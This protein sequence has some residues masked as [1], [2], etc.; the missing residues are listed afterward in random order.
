MNFANLSFKNAGYVW[1]AGT[2]LVC[3]MIIYLFYDF[4][5]TPQLAQKEQLNNQL[6]LEKN[7]VAVVEQFAATHPDREGYLRE[8]DAEVVR[9]NKLLPDRANMGETVDFLEGTAK[10]TNVVFGALTTEK[11]VY[12]NGW[13]ESRIGFK[14]LG[15]YTDLLEFTRQL[16]NG[17]RF[18][19]VRGVEFH[20]RVMLNQQLWGQEEVQKMVEKEL[21]SKVNILVKPI[22]ERGLL[23]KQSLVIMNVYLMVATQG[24]LP[25]AENAPAAPQQVPAKS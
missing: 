10:T 21:S 2:L 12:K 7:R 8:L 24:R 5:L 18:M 17:P 15:A 25:E 13:T 9:V 19:A 6:Q 20:D 23:N 22:I 11:S 1:L 14:V 16:D 3:L 4:I